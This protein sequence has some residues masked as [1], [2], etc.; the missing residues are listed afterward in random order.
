MTTRALLHSEL[1]NRLGDTANAVWLDAELDGF[2]DY[3]IKGLYPT[4]YQRQMAVTTAGVGPMQTMPTGARNL[5]MV[6]LQAV[7]SARVRVVR[8]WAEGSTT[9]FVGKTGITGATLVWGWTSGWDAPVSSG[10]AL[11]IPLEAEEVVILRAHISALEK[12]LSDRVSQEK[13]FALNVRQAAT[14]QEVAD[15]IDGLQVSLRARI[16]HAIPLPEIRH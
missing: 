1:E 5:Y 2:I 12:L 14:E 4:F 13:Y 3:A 15:T 6:G 11:T 10:T 9:A 7:G 16:E 8:G